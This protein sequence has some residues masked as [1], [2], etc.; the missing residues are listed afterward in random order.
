MKTDNRFHYLL[1][2]VWLKHFLEL[3]AYGL[4][5]I[6]PWLW[7]QSHDRNP[8][9]KFFLT[10]RNE[11][12]GWQFV[13]IGLGVQAERSL[14]ATELL[15]GHFVGADSQ[16]VSVFAAN[17][18]PGQGDFSSVEHTPEKCWVRTGFRIAAHE[19]PSQIFISIAGRQIPFQCRI[20]SHSNLANPEITLWA[21]CGR[22]DE[23]RYE[24]PQDQMERAST[25][26]NQFRILMASYKNLWAIFRERISFRINPLARKQ[27]IRF[28]TPMTKQWQ[29]GVVEL[30][31]FGERW[32]TLD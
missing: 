23:A 3:N 11:I 8:E 22:W 4:A 5:I 7:F 30:A 29:Q 21:A 1:N 28:S 10:A 31:A 20:L 17:W 32:L 24:P 2:C 27:F 13:P 9:K 26:Q 12:Q 19:V 6:L 25:V 15:N 16:R 14:G 18:K